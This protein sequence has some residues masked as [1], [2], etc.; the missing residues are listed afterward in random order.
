MDP[1][2]TNK[3]LN[4]ILDDFPSYD[5][6]SEAGTDMAIRNIESRLSAVVSFEARDDGH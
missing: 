3:A 6:Q 5:L 1:E 4:D 2:K